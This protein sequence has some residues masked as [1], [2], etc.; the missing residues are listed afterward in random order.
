MTVLVDSGGAN[1]GSVQQAL[2]RLGVDAP[3]TRDAKQIASAERVILPGVGAAAWA[4]KV[5]ADNGLDQL[6]PTLSQPVLGICLG[7]QLMCASSAEGD[8]D[9][10]GMFGLPVKRFTGSAEQRVPHMGWNRLLP[11]GEHPLMHGVSD[12]DY[13]YFVHS[14]YVPECEATIAGC[15]YFGGFSAAIAQ[16]NFMAAQFH[17]ERS[18]K[19]GARIL[20]NFLEMPS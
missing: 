17:P 16:G 19:V 18:A 8:V 14:Y 6:L 10:L 9:C 3:L 13:A 4:M 12:Q 1:I 20:K 11:R 5:L 2:H 15:D 7:M